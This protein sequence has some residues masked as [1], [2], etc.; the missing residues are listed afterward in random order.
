[1]STRRRLHSERAKCFKIHASNTKNPDTREMYLRLAEVRLHSLSGMNAK[2]GKCISIGK[3][4][5]KREV[6]LRL[7]QTSTNLHFPRSDGKSSE[8]L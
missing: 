1:V 3:R 6:Q 5:S 4:Q 8:R 2:Q 7:H